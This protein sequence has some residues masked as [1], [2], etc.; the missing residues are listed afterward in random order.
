MTDKSVCNKKD[1]GTDMEGQQGQEGDTTA[2]AMGLCFIS[3]HFS[4]LLSTTLSKSET[5][6]E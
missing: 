5:Y 2:T 4:L 1:V 3:L 6:K